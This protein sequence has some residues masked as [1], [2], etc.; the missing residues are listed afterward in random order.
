MFEMPMESL[1]E[2]VQ[3]LVE[4]GRPVSVLWQ[5]ADSLAFIARGREYRNE[6]HVD[7]SDELM[8]MIKGDMRLHFRTPDGKEEVAVVPEGSMICAPAGTPHSPRCSPDSFALVIE[9]RRAD[10]EV[11]RFLWFCPNCDALVHEEEFIVRD[12]RD[13]PV[14]AAYRRYAENE[15]YRTCGGCGEVLPAPR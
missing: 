6:F 11:D 1:M 5:K 14:S 9:R 8:Y 13:D 2:H 7:P 10:G 15:D 4:S 3:R 12:Y